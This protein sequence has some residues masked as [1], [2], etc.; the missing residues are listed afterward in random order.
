MSR[1]LKIS[2]DDK[3]EYFNRVIIP[4]FHPLHKLNS[5]EDRDDWMVKRALE[6][7]FE[8]KSAAELRIMYGTVSS[9]DAAEAKMAEER[10]EKEKEE[11]RQVRADERRERAEEK[12]RRERERQERVDEERREKEREK[13]EEKERRERAGR[14]PPYVYH[15][16]SSTCYLNLSA[17]FFMISQEWMSGG[18]IISLMPVFDCSTCPV[19][20]VPPRM[21]IIF[22]N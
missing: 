4:S 3:I 16:R 5:E 8:P 17:V 21:P 15:Y 2:S 9:L 10:Q 12:E 1:I 11:E 7:G 19:T 13:A 18:F 14:I 6:A 22:K 20:R